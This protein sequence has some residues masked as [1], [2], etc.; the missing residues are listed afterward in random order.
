MAYRGASEG[1]L[2]VTLP[3]GGLQLQ[4]GETA[5]GYS[6][7]GFLREPQG[8]STGQLRDSIWWRQPRGC[9]RQERDGGR[10]SGAAVPLSRTYLP[11]F[12]LPIRSSKTCCA[13]SSAVIGK[14]IAAMMRSRLS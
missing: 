1:R 7:A 2:A 4:E 12:P 14:S 8:R 11:H 13:L 3:P 5:V 9:W 6:C 10:L